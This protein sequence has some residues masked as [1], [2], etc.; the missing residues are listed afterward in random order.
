MPLAVPD[1]V[2]RPAGEVG[3]LCVAEVLD[4][5]FVDVALH[6]VHVAG[7]M[8]HLQLPPPGQLIPGD[9]RYT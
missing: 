7:V 4:G 3:D 2:L 9:L 1:L 8:R 5:E 6:A